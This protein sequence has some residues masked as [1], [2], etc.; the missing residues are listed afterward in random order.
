MRSVMAFVAKVLALALLVIT[1]SM[2]GTARAEYPD[3]PIT[4]IVGF[5]A[6]GGSDTYARAL[7]NHLQEP[8]GVP[9]AVVNRPGAAGMIAAKAAN[10]ARS[11]GYTLLL[12][13]GGTFYIKATIDGEKAPATPA[14]FQ[15]LGAVGKLVTGLIVPK[16]S[17]FKSAKELVDFAKANPGKLRWSHPGRGSLH[18]MAGSLF[19]KENGIEVQDVPFKGG[20]N[21]RNAVAGQQVDFGFM[22]V[23][24]VAGF[25]DKLRALGVADNERDLIYKDIPTFGEQDLPELG[26]ANTQIVWGKKDLPADVIS[27]LEEAIQKTASSDAYKEMLAKAGLGGFHVSVDESRERMDNFAKVLGPVISD[28]ARKGKE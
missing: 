14:D 12:H 28:S 23:Q 3:K 20:S 18:A 22:G 2:V 9:V 5:S 15:S 21:A 10:N 8:L 27:K 6:G 11:D 17:P 13:G 7:A 26:V 24:L 1:S 19:L 4:L 16:D 25:E